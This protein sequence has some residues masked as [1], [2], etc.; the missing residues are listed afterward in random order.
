MI[1]LGWLEALIKLSFFSD[2]PKTTPF[3][4]GR[5]VGADVGRYETGVWT[6]WNEANVEIFYQLQPNPDGKI[7][8]LKGK[9]VSINL[10]FTGG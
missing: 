5:A 3:A 9:K 10:C 7:G 1:H 4:H 2:L 6:P 8:G